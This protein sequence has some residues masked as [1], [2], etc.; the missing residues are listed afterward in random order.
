MIG[1]ITHSPRR[2]LGRRIR[3]G[4][5]NHHRRGNSR[6]RVQGKFNRVSLL[7]I[8]FG[9]GEQVPTFGRFAASHGDVFY[10]ISVEEHLNNEIEETDCCF[11]FC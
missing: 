5:I 8:P 4:G 2:G 10:K 11:N 9:L 7:S 3:T 1:I 6:G